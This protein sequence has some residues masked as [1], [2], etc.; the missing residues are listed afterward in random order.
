MLIGKVIGT[1]VATHKE[2]KYTGY[3]LQVVQQLNFDLSEGPGQWIVADPMGAG[4]GDLVLV[5]RGRE[6][7]FP[8]EPDAASID[9]AIIGIID[10]INYDAEA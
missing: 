2:A 7:T 9:R 5:A 3:K 10:N 6:A 8:F 4:V 1:V